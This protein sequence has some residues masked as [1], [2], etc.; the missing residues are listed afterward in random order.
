MTPYFTQHSPPALVAMLPPM[1]QISNDDGS[2][3]YHR[4][5]SAAASF[6]SALY[7]PGW[8]TA[9]RVTGSTVMSRI[10]SVDS[11]IPPSRAVAPPER[12]LPA[13]RVTT[14]TWF[15]LAQRSTVCTSSVRR[16]RMI[17]SGLPAE[18]S[19]ARSCR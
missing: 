1:L 5:C 16:G 4:P 12:P 3:G 8:H 17:A 9:V 19:K 14:G 2:G 10:F 7:R 13:P 18:G 6:T 15:A 11:T